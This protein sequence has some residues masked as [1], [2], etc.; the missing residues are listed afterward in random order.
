MAHTPLPHPRTAA[1]GAL[2]FGLLLCTAAGAIAQPTGSW[3]VHEGPDAP[4]SF[5]MT[6]E[7][8]QNMGFLNGAQTPSATDPA[9]SA[10]SEDLSL[11]WTGGQTVPCRAA[12]DYAYFQTSVFPTAGDRYA[13]SFVNVD[14]AAI[15]TV[16]NEDN[17]NGVDVEGSVVGLRERRS[18]DITSA[19]LPGATNR[20]VVTLANVCGPTGTL[21]LQVEVEPGGGE[22]EAG[23]GDEGAAMAMACKGALETLV[24]NNYRFG[25]A[26]DPDAVASGAAMSFAAAYAQFEEVAPSCRLLLEE[27][28]TYV[29][30]RR[31]DR[32]AGLVDRHRSRIA[33]RLAPNLSFSDNVGYLDG[34]AGVQ[35]QGSRVRQY[36]PEQ[37]QRQFSCDVAAERIALSARLLMRY[38]DFVAGN[39]RAGD[40]DGDI[41][42]NEPAPTEPAPTGD[43]RADDDGPVTAPAPTGSGFP[44]SAGQGLEPGTTYRAPSG[45]YA[46]TL[47]ADGNLVLTRADGGYVWGFDQ[48]SEIDR[49]RV[50]GVRV[51]PDGNLVAVDADGATVWRALSSG[52][53]PAARLVLTSAGALQLVS[54][55]RGVQWSSDGILASTIDVF[56]KRPPATSCDEVDGWPKCLE[57]NDPEITIRGSSRVSDS[58]MNAVANVYAE[59]TARLTDRYPRN[60]FDGFGV[61]I[62]NGESL[63]QLNALDPIKDYHADGYP[64]TDGLGGG[65][66][67][68]LR[69]GACCDGPAGSGDHVWISEQMICKSGVA[70]RNDDL[71][72]GRVRGE[73]DEN[74]RSFDQV[75][76]EFGHSIDQKY[77][78]RPTRLPSLYQ[79]NPTE[80]FAQSIQAYFAAPAIQQT[81]AQMAFLNELF[82]SR[83]RFS[84]EGYAP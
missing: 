15:V 19:L 31:L 72:R 47:Q 62:T 63:D 3:Q 59:I 70:T 67:N 81:D 23:G 18:V 17:P 5:G 6:V 68:T 52:A 10:A 32:L 41:G 35:Q 39:D 38:M 78:L 21:Q 27:P 46:A 8:G 76:H 7:N 22:P 30:A 36:C 40:D 26:P 20:V 69:G 61:Y 42:A 56:S 49:S 82:S 77:G 1:R 48:L 84:C 83:V 44:F 75:I 16:Y 43:D 80:P 25:M 74:Y 37:H 73:R 34:P 14:D 66:R 33:E 60:A 11:R 24:A 28:E 45:G 9:W 4:Y 51:Q 65:T 55:S 54:P 50:R 57:L 79:G 64:G 58:A 12:A 29:S 53:D 13:L 71:A 2:L